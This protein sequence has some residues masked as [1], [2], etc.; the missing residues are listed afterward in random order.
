M[1][2]PLV[3]IFSIACF[4]ALWVLYRSYPP[5][6][7]EVNLVT[8]GLF[9][10]TAIRQLFTGVYFMELCLTGLFFL[11]RDVDGKATCTAQAVI[12]IAATVLTASFQYSLDHGHGMH[13]LSLKR[14]I[15][16]QVDQTRCKTS[17]QL[18]WGCR[19]EDQELSSVEP[20]QAD[21]SQD[22]ALSSTR[23]VIWIPKDSLGIADDEICQLRR[24]YDCI[25]ISNEGAT[26]N[27]EG[28]LKPWGSPPEKLTGQV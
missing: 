21:L 6:L 19:T 12:M 27:E 10:P 1:I 16:R 17:G 7:T 13:W 23:P 11:V 3:L 22:E 14:F 20:T 2:A 18:D 25:W 15:N 24:A 8:Y 26:L 9:Y 28:K 5:K 4:G